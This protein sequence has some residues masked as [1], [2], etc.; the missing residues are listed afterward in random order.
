MSAEDV[1][2]SQREERS[3]YLAWFAGGLGV[4]TAGAVV[5]S[6]I[7]C[8]GCSYSWA[9]FVRFG[10][11]SDLEEYRI[12]VRNS[13]VSQSE[14][15]AYVRRFEAVEDRLDRGELDMSFIEWVD[16]SSDIEDVLADGRIEAWEVSTFEE[17]L[18]KMER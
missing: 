1:W 14:K 11:R 18:R 17:N 12:D 6:V 16:V 7:G 13:N 4:A 2:A 5:L 8:C 10:I 9:A 3:G 15:D